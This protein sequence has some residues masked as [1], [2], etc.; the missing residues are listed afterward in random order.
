M[1]DGT[2][3]LLQFAA[4]NYIDVV[5]TVSIK[6]AGIVLSV[7]S[8]WLFFRERGITDK[9]IAASVMFSGVLILYL[10]LSAAQAIAVAA[11][12]VALMAVAL[13]VTRNEI[14]EPADGAAIAEPPSR[15]D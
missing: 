9:V 4:Y 8:G 15:E 3:Q 14:Q 6:R 11:F 5:I 2:S 13:Y 10:P 7:L 12:T 1:L